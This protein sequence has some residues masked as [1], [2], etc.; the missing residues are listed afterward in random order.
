[1][2]Q[3]LHQTLIDAKTTLEARDLCVRFNNENSLWIANETV[4]GGD[5][6]IVSK[7]A[8]ALNRWA[9]HWVA[10]F[11][12]KGMRTYEVPGSL[13][14][15]VTLILAVYTRHRLDKGTLNEAFRRTVLDPDSYLNGR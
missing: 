13:A 9:N 15:V 12:A 8:C 5:G 4:D 1:M 3:P 11:P 10:V 14:E 7:D 2:I 6:F